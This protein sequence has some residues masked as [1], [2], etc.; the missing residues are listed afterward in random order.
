MWSPSC[1]KAGQEPR[2]HLPPTRGHR[3]QRG[4]P[5][6]TQA[7][8]FKEQIPRDRP[9]C[10]LTSFQLQRCHRD[11]QPRARVRE[12]GPR[13][14]T[15]QS[16]CTLTDEAAPQIRDRGGPGQVMDFAKKR[17]RPLS[18]SALPAGSTE[19]RQGAFCCREK[20]ARGLRVATGLHSCGSLSA[21]LLHNQGE[22]G[23]Y[24]LRRNADCSHSQ[25]PVDSPAP[26]CL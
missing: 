4:S 20:G 26:P 3:H 17:A 24:G 13:Q 22:P 14:G 9:T 11:E 16:E 6:T 12:G 2:P 15:R 5:F 18:G 1:S 10:Q 23:F 8:S 7:P 21:P 19:A 25:Q